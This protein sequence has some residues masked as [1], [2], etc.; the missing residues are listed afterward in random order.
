MKKNRIHNIPAS[1]ALSSCLALSLCLLSSVSSAEILIIANSSMNI[2]GADVADLYT[3]EKTSAG[4]ATVSLS[5]NKAA[6]TEFC[7]KAL[8]MEPAKYN[9]HW[10]K[11]S[12]RDGIASPKPKS[13]DSEV[14]DFVK[15]TPNGIGYISGTAPSGV[16]QVTKY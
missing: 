10:A 16:K 14:I 9:A 15:A 7:Q 11:K 1:L 3:G 6:L 5:D 2:S 4:G 12:F 8:K 13:S